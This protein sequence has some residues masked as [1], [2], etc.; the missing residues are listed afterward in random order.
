MISRGNRG[1]ALEALVAG[2]RGTPTD[3]ADWQAVIALANRTLLTPDLFSS[4][5]RAGQIHQLPEDVREYL[6]FVHDCNRERNLRLRTQLGEAVAALN[7][8]DISPLLLKGAVPLFLSPAGLVPSRMTSDLDLAVNPRQEKV[9]R[10]CL[11]EL[12]Y[13]DVAGGRGMARQQDAGMLELRSTRADCY[14]SPKLIQRDG[15]RVKIPPV[16]SRAMHWMVHDLL[17]EG[18]YW[19]GRIDL[20]HLHDLARLAENEDVDWMS[21]QGSMSDRSARNALETQ[22]LAMHHFFGTRIPEK[23]AKRPIVRFQHWRRVFTA[24]H[25]VIGAPLRLAGNLTWGIWRFSRAYGLARRGP[26][27]LLRRIARTLFDPRTKI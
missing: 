24:T 11:E 19:R 1:N 5:A 21:L 3:R 4:L 2:L 6:R 13:V 12:G 8:S 26:P 25:P 20:R 15:L 16:Q 23:C 17:K 7:R 14:H 10:D 9:A 27:Y 22:L 18:D